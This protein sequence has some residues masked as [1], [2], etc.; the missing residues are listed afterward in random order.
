MANAITL[1]DPLELER[2]GCEVVPHRSLLETDDYSNWRKQIDRWVDR[3]PHLRTPYKQGGLPPGEH[4]KKYSAMGC[5]RRHNLLLWTVGVQKT[6]TALLHILGWF[7]DQL[8]YGLPWD[9]LNDV[10]RREAMKIQV[11]DLPAGAIHI[12]TRKK[13]LKKTWMSE[14]KRMG[15]DQFAEVIESESQLMN[16][17]AP[18]FLYHFDFPSRIQTEKGRCMKSRGVGKRLKADG[19]L[20][21]RGEP[22]GKLIRDKRP[23]SLLI[24]DEIHRLRPDTA[25]TTELTHIRK[26]AKRVIGLTATPMDGWLIHY[27]CVLEFIYGP[28]TVSFPYQSASDFARRYMKTKIVTQDVVT[29]GETVGK[30]RPM[31]GVHPMQIPNFVK[32][33]RHLAHRLTSQDPEVKKNVKFPPAH[34]YRVL[35][36]MDPKQELYYKELHRAHEMELQANL[37][38]SKGR[39]LNRAQARS[40]ILKLINTLRMASAVPSALSYDQ[41]ETEKFK[42]CLDICKKAEADGRKVL[43]YTNFIEESRIINK[44]L[45]DNGV[46]SVRIY[47]SDPNATPRSLSEQAQMDVLDQ[48]EDEDDISTCCSNLELIAEGLTLTWAS[49]L[50]Y[51]SP[52]WRGNLYAQGLGRVIRPGQVWDWVDVYEL[53]ND[54]TVEVYMEKMIRAKNR[55]SAAFVDLDFSNAAST[56][57][58]AF[59]LGQLLAD[60]GAAQA[61]A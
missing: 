26:K 24:V 13:I 18:I 2:M 20:T 10:Q 36:E 46:G 40:N 42:K 30:K 49:V 21:F 48:Y 17:K 23:P 5:C 27:G 51:L 14:M 29:G 11:A 19:S 8:F 33:T 31:P 50:I 4:Q 58:D 22:M 12:V 35:I 61:A 53:T 16:S 47:V 25:R 39:G 44:Y 43:I 1:R 52:C 45:K 3:I 9:K 15:L 28:N 55:A 59:E 34:F 32:V 54:N 56:E 37:A 6:A 38:H 7:G 41:V 60:Q 57:L